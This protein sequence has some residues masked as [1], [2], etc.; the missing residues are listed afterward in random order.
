MTLETIIKLFHK[1]EAQKLYYT[2]PV[3]AQR[4]AQMIAAA[5]REKYKE[6]VALLRTIHMGNE[7]ARS[8][9]IIRAAINLLNAEAPQE[10]A[11]AI[12]T[13]GQA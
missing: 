13:R 11:D 6:A 9:T 10:L 8:Q 12:R 7:S 4:V 3:A 2:D 1:A 5:E